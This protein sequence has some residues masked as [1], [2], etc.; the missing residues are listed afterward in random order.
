MLGHGR[1]SLT[2]VRPS[3]RDI[4]RPARISWDDTT[5]LRQDGSVLRGDVYDPM[6]DAWTPF[7]ANLVERR[8][9]GGSYP[10]ELTA[11]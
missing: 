10:P 1:E 5:N 6:D 7:A 8:V 3:G 11:E 4:W 2:T 9:T